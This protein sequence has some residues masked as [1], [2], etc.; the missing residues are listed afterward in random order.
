[1]NRSDLYSIDGLSY[2]K[3]NEKKE[4]GARL[5]T[6]FVRFMTYIDPKFLFRGVQD[7]KFI[8]GIK[9]IVKDP[10][11]FRGFL[12]AADMDFR[13]FVETMVYALPK[14]FTYQFIRY[15]QGEYLGITQTKKKKK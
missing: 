4:D 2:E 1:M 14:V 12:K 3:I 13:E 10:P 15:I 6:L 5:L 9:A 8:A 7:Q 11:L